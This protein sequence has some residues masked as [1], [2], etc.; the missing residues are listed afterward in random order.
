M[1]EENIKDSI[2]K[3]SL[4]LFSQKG[5]DS[6]GVQ[7]ICKKCKISK[8]TLYYYY[9]SK[10]G[11]LKRILDHYGSLYC[12]ILATT[13]A[14]EKDFLK[15]LTNLLLANIEFAKK[16]PEF[17]RLYNTLDFSAK[18]NESYYAHLQLKSRIDKIYTD[19]FFKSV[20]TFGNMKGHENL[21]RIS[22]QAIVVSTVNSVLNE[23]LKDD[24]ETLYTIIKSFVYGVAN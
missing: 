20:E 7:E 13:I 1:S 5:F 14:N 22:F 10:L 3:T 17:F 21:Y 15:N 18:G 8:P 9:G 12:Q 4:T 24:N 19:L 11:L 2:L 6:V 16:S 23:E